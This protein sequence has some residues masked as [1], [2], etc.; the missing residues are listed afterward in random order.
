[1]HKNCVL[2]ISGVRLGNN[3]LFGGSTELPLDPPKPLAHVREQTLTKS[4]LTG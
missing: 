3:V 2:V 1:M 4:S